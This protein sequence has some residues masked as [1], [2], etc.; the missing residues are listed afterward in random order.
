MG[1]RM[2]VHGYGDHA[3]YGILDVSGRFVNTFVSLTHFVGM[4][5][6]DGKLMEHLRLFADCESWTFIIGISPMSFVKSARIGKPEV[7]PLPPWTFL[8]V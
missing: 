1:E 8:C 4:S 3:N 6:A 7:N 2:D 5:R